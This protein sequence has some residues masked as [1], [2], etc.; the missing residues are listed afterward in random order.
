[1]IRLSDSITFESRSE[2]E[3]L[4][5]VISKYVKQNPAEKNN[6]V[7]KRFYYLLDDMDMCWQGSMLK[8]PHNCTKYKFGAIINKKWKNKKSMTNTQKND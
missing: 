6:E 5:E 4:L 3:E 8:T 1:M 7:L 2:I